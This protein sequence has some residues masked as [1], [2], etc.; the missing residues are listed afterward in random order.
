MTVRRHDFGDESETWERQYKPSTCV[1]DVG[2]YLR[3]YAYRSAKARRALP[4]RAHAYGADPAERLHFFPAA[5]PPAPLVVFVHGGYWQEL[6]ETES[7]FA[8]PD[9]VRRGIAF[10]ALGYGLAPGHRLDEIVGMVRRG[11]LWLREHAAGL[12][13][14]PARIVLAGSSA[15]AQLVAMCLSRGMAC[16]AV[17][18]SGVYDLLPL[19]RTSIGAAIRLSEAEAVRNS[20]VRH[21]PAGLPPLLVARGDNETAAFA[22]QQDWFVAAVTETG[23][24]VT[25]LVVAGRNHFDLP[26]G[27]GDPGDPLGRFVS[28]KL[29]VAV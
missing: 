11:V 8:A 15:G 1:P 18:L 13:V 28:D 2:A 26:F 29:A 25:D 9:L 19:C 14:D 21:V 5:R 6:S 23:A 20:P 17:L 3:E 24:H 4:W 22:D 7:S 16:G 27:L 10:A 12:G